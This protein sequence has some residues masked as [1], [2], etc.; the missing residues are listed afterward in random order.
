MLFLYASIR[1]VPT[2]YKIYGCLT[3]SKTLL[4][5]PKNQKV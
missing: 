4:T 2:E 5:L 1:R 3:D